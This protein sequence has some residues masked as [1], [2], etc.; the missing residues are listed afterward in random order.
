M[1]RYRLVF[2]PAVA[3]ILYFLLLVP[4]LKACW[5][6]QLYHAVSSGFLIGYLCYDTI[7]YFLHHASPKK[8]Y[9]KNLK[10]YHM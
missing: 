9:F 3:Y 8:G 4:F 5:P 10:I 6:D 1:D 7:H 2:P